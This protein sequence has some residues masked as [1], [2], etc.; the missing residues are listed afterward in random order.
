MKLEYYVL[1]C[2]IVASGVLCAHHLVMYVHIRI[3]YMVCLYVSCG[4]HHFYWC[5]V[6]RVEDKC[7]CLHSVV[8]Q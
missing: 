4:A 6:V 2:M 1:F 5:V 8:L 7:V 3:V